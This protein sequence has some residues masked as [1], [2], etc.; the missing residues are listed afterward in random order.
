MSLAASSEGT[1]RP[2]TLDD[3]LPLHEFAARRAEYVDAH[4]RYCERYRR[5]HLGPHACLTFENRQTQWFRVQEMLR[6]LR[7]EDVNL[8]R[9]E[10]DFWNRLLPR[11]DHLL[12]SFSQM[13]ASDLGACLILDSTRVPGRLLPARPEDRALGIANWIEFPLRDGDRTRL[14]DRDVP[15]SIEVAGHGSTS[16][17]EDVRQSLI[18]DLSI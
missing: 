7:L 1:V 3:L 6:V 16:L 12:A 17:T 9:G 11:R 8:V 10:L 14:I 5:V 2:L 4:R 13:E 18:D 15:A